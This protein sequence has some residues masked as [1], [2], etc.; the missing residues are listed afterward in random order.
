[1]DEIT[2]DETLPADAIK[3]T[4]SPFLTTH[5]ALGVCVREL[6]TLSDEL[7][8]GIAAMR[9]RLGAPK[10]VVR[11]PPGRC[12]VQLGPVALTMVWLKDAQDTIASGQLLIG[13][14]R[15]QVAPQVEHQWERPIRTAPQL[16]AKLLWETI[17]A[18][19]AD[20]QD[21][22]RWNP[23][24]ADSLPVTGGRLAEE[25]VEQLRAAYVETSAALALVEGTDTV[26]EAAI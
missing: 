13:V 24:V 26:Q 22:W 6:S 12:I 19:E 2:I 5:R 9:D 21:T 14:W 3:F 23:V 8:A 18:A 10:E 17:L 7:V 11:R 20:S 16:P 4:P 25:C 15:G 1:M